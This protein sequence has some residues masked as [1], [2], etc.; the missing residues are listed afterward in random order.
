MRMLT[1][2]IISRVGSYVIPFTKIF[3]RE[4]VDGRKEGSSKI[5]IEVFYIGLIR[6]WIKF[7][8]KLFR[9]PTVLFLSKTKCFWI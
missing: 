5:M 1:L 9:K 8:I 3:E 4:L 6:R 2:V 7:F